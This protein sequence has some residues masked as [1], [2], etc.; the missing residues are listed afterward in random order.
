MRGSG[1]E[2][3]WV[4]MMFRARMAS[5]TRK[6][7][8]P[9]NGRMGGCGFS[10]PPPP[11][12]FPGVGRSFSDRGAGGR[13]ATSSARDRPGRARGGAPLGADALADAL[14]PVSLEL[15]V[16]PADLRED[17]VRD[18][19]LVLARRVLDPLV[20]HRLPV[21]D[22]DLREVEAPPVPDPL[23]T[24]DGDGHDRG[25]GARREPPDPRLDLAGEVAGARAPAL[26]VHGD[27]AA[28]L[29]D[30]LGGDEGL[31][32]RVSAPD[33]EDAAVR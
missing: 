23:G 30:R 13:G 21:V 28:V 26:A 7:R 22:G 17:V 8:R 27:R 33:G 20:E 11:P 19:L 4:R 14:A 6:I 15:G 12:T 1:R 29:E 32:V 24:V 5:T 3:Y 25:A 9:P 16:E 10:P 31:L 18:G 2:R